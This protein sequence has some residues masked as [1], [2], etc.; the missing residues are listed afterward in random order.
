MHSHKKS[1][2]TFFLTLLT[3][4]ILIPTITVS[5]ALPD[6][7]LLIK[8]SC[9][10]IVSGYFVDAL[11]Q[12]H[13]LARNMEVA[14][15]PVRGNVASFNGI[16][17][18]MKLPDGFMENLDEITISVWFYCDEP[19]DRQW[20]RIYDFGNS[21]QEYFS[22]TPNSDAGVIQ[23]GHN[24]FWGLFDNDIRADEN[25]N[26]VTV[27]QGNASYRGKWTHAVVTV[28][29][30]ET[31]MYIDGRLENT[32]KTNTLPRDIGYTTQNYFGKSMYADPY[33]KGMMD[34]ICIYSVA[35]T[36]EQVVELNKAASF[37]TPDSAKETVPAAVKT[38]A[39]HENEVNGMVARY[40]LNEITDG[41]VVDSINGNDG[42]VYGFNA[43]AEIVRDADRGDVL[44]LDGR[45][46][47]VHL[48]DGLFADL[49]EMTITCWY[50]FE[51]EGDDLYRNSNR[52]W[53]RVFDMGSHTS[54]SIYLSPR[55]GD[56]GSAGSEV[57][58]NDIGGRVTV[59]RSYTNRWVHA[60]ITFGNG[61]H[62]LYIDGE[63]QGVAE[64]DFTP[65][66]LGATFEN[67][68]GKSMY[69]DPLFRGRVSELVIYN[70]VLSDDEINNIAIS[71]SAGGSDAVILFM[72]IILGIAAICCLV[73]IIVTKKPKEMKF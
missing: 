37:V 48:P 6:D 71:V 42:M 44:R 62:K 45:R 46:A 4:I 31:R 2:T 23:I 26:L 65:K 59:D 40:A 12:G 1:F 10:E 50:Y 61:E 28:D 17:G 69:A 3:L 54:S 67:H 43:G 19:E 39:T 49:D 38:H 16:N 35:L 20:S 53:S 25:Y 27:L 11:G 7:K 9:D 5:A 32:T 60:A 51:T 64:I 58:L 41:L 72:A 18:F 47:F 52:D 24:H 55:C 21:H 22:L 8:Y 33:F 63:L 14:S 70:R 66:D 36:E 13:A 34:D 56:T 73:F 68:I 57:K 30:D 15:D 29:R